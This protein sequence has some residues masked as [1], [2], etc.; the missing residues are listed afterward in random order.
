MPIHKGWNCPQKITQ[1]VEQVCLQ[2]MREAA[3]KKFSWH[4]FIRLIR[5]GLKP[6]LS[7]TLIWPFD[8]MAATSAKFDELANLVTINN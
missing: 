5:P 8:S 1:Y 2:N 6:I 3:K 7:I 4:N